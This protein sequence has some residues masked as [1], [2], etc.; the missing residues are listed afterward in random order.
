MK[1]LIRIA[2]ITAL[3]AMVSAFACAAEPTAFDATLTVKRTEN[4]ITVIV[5]NDPGTNAVLAEKKPTLK[6]PCDFQEAYVTYRGNVIPSKLADGCIAFT[7]AEGVEPYFIREGSSAAIAV[8]AE[9]SGKTVNA[10][11]SIRNSDADEPYLVVAAAY[12]ENGRMLGFQSRALTA[13]TTE[14]TITFELSNCADAAKVRVFFLDSGLTP[15]L[16]AAEAAVKG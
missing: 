4:A 6:I 16:E 2:A 7:V 15:V 14:D 9:K 10:E 12:S 1:K 8:S 11:V 3:L 5:G 13:G